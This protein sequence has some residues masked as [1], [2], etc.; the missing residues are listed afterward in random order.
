MSLSIKLYRINVLQFN[1]FVFIGKDT[2]S[3]LQLVNDAITVILQK[4]AAL[5]N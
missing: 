3:H 5:L 1:V 2:M 4:S